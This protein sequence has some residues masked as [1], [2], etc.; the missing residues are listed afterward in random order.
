MNGLGDPSENESFCEVQSPCNGFSE[1]KLQT[2]GTRKLALNPSWELATP[3]EWP[4][5]F[6]LLRSIS[7]CCCLLL[8]DS[9]LDGL[10]IFTIL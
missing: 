6:T 5:I 1:S 7:C 4:A 3:F 9:S 2:L 10:L 8:D